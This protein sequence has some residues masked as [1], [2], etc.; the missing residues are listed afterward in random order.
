MI[1]F[2]AVSALLLAAAGIYG[3]VNNAVASCAREIALTDG[4]GRG[5]GPC[6]RRNNSMGND[7]APCR[8]RRVGPGAAVT[9]LLFKLWI[10]P[11]NGRPHKFYKLSNDIVSKGLVR[12]ALANCGEVHQPGKVAPIRR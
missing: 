6:H 12:Q 2:F 7:S 8:C 10:K 1:S 11:H 4:L 3:L 9:C 5:F